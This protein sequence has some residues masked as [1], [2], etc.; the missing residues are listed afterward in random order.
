MHKHTLNIKLKEYPQ[1]STIHWFNYY[2]ISIWWRMLS[3]TKSKTQ[4]THNWELDIQLQMKI[5][6]INNFIR[7]ANNVLLKNKSCKVITTGNC[8]QA[9]RVWPKMNTCSQ[10]E[11]NKKRWN[12]SGKFQRSVQ[13][14]RHGRNT[15]I[16]RIS[17]SQRARCK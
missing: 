17:Q 6:W 2:K 1:A 10:D 15:V 8:K 5:H 13:W 9:T 3:N 14:L 4:W 7:L 16:K 11:N 12:T